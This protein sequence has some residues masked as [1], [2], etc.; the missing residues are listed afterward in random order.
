MG[1]YKNVKKLISC[2]RNK[3]QETYK[4]QIKT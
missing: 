1:I 4:L 2:S 3:L